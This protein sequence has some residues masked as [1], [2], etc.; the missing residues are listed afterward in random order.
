MAN[1]N[2]NFEHEEYERPRDLVPK[3]ERELF[4][5]LKHEGHPLKQKEHENR[6]I[7]LMKQFESL[8][9][10]SFYYQRAKFGDFF[11]ERKFLAS[12]LLGHFV[13][14]LDKFSAELCATITKVLG[15]MLTEFVLHTTRPMVESI[16]LN[17]D[18]LLRRLCVLLADSARVAYYCSEI[19]AKCCE[20]LVLARKLLD[21]YADVEEGEVGGDG[22]SSTS[23]ST[24][25]T[26]LCPM[27]IKLLDSTWRLI[28]FSHLVS[29]FNYLDV[30]LMGNKATARYA[31]SRDHDQLVATFDR[32]LECD[33]VYARQRALSLF[34]RLIQNRNLPPMLITNYTQRLD[35]LRLLVQLL[36]R[37]DQCD[38]KTDF[39]KVFD[40]WALFLRSSANAKND[41]MK[42]LVKEHQQ[43]LYGHVKTMQA[44]KA[45]A[46]V[47]FFKPDYLDLVRQLDVWLGKVQPPSPSSGLARIS[48]D[49]SLSI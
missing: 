41:E 34:H 11:L 17:S 32:L 26:M 44:M 31:F 1:N 19:L 7:L 43:Q 18:L 22:T 13:M 15:Y 47:K 3:I 37:T 8:L 28:D 48:S 6:L 2:N 36:N 20:D 24:T 25:T 5:V 23:P 39:V 16:R 21:L 30:L 45:V 33:N 38:N 49:E 29:I 27:Y 42:A 35:H 9:V 10:G 4:R 46:D 12:N 14:N 40:I